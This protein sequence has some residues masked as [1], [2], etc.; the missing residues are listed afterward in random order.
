MKI[1]HKLLFASLVLTSCTTAELSQTR[2]VADP[3]VAAVVSGYAATYGVPPP[4]TQGVVG[5]VQ[6]QLWGMLAQ[7]TAKQPIAQG[8][9]IPAVGAAVTR[10]DAASP[11]PT[12]ANLTAALKSLGAIK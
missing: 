6:N 2:A 4:I 3:I 7:A 12:V 5:I 11:A 9:S 1:C 8:S 10:V